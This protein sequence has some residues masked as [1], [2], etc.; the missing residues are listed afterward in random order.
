MASPPP[1]S[2]TPRRWRPAGQPSAVVETL[3]QLS[4]S[5]DP[6]SP[7]QEFL[8]PLGTPAVVDGAAELAANV[9]GDS[10]NR[11][12]DSLYAG[13]EA[14]GASFN[15]APA[16]Q[17]TAPAAAAAALAPSPPSPNPPD[18]AAH[19]ES[20]KPAPAPPTEATASA[21][22]LPAAITAPSTP[23]PPSPVKAARPTK[24]WTPK[25]A[26]ATPTKT[27][28]RASELIRM[29]ESKNDSPAPERRPAGAVA[30]PF[31]EAVA[32]KVPAAS[33]SRQA[34]TSSTPTTT[35]TRSPI[36]SVQKMVAS[37]RTRN[38][39]VTGQ[40]SSL[41]SSTPSSMLRKRSWNVSIRRRR[42][43]EPEDKVAEQVPDDAPE[44]R[45]NSTPPHP[46]PV[47]E[48]SF[49]SQSSLPSP[50]PFPLAPKTLTGEPL[51]TG[52]LFYFNVYED[53]EPEDY[54]WVATDARLYADGLELVWRTPAG[55]K[56]T[57][58]LDVEYCEEVTSTYSPTNPIAN[59][60]GALAARKRG[61][62]FVRGLYP[63]KMVYEDGTE[64]LGC[65]SAIE[66]VRWVKAIALRTLNYLESQGKVQQLHNARI[67]NQLDR[68][69]N[70]VDRSARHF[71]SLDKLELLDE[72]RK[73]EGLVDCLR[74]LS[75]PDRLDDQPPPL[76]SKDSVFAE[77]PPPSPT[78]SVSTLSDTERPVTPP[79]FLLPESF[80][81]RMEDMGHLLGLVMGQQKDI[82]EE[83]AYRRELDA[84]GPARMEAMFAQILHQLE[85]NA[86]HQKPLAPLPRK[87]PAS[88]ESWSEVEG[89]FYP[90]S[91]S[92]YS[93]DFGQRTPA[94]PNTLHSATSL[95]S[96]IPESLLEDDT[97]EPEFDEEYEVGN[98][99]PASPAHEQKQYRT[100][101]P[102][103]VVR[104]R[105]Q[106]LEY[107]SEVEDEEAAEDVERVLADPAPAPATPPQRPIPY[108]Q[109]QAD[110]RPEEETVYRD[111]QPERRRPTTR[112]PPPEPVELPTPVNSE[113]RKLRDAALD[114]PGP[115]GPQSRF[116]RP[117]RGSMHRFGRP[118]SPLSTTYVSRGFR[119]VPL[120][121]FPPP[122][123]MPIPMMAPPLRQGMPAFGRPGFFPPPGYGP[124][125]GGPGM[126]HHHLPP[127]SGGIG[128]TTTA[129]STNSPLPPHSARLSTHGSHHHTPTPSATTSSASVAD[130]AIV[131]PPVHSP[132]PPITIK[133]TPASIEETRSASDGVPSVAPGSPSAATEPVPPPTASAY[134]AF[135]HPM[136]T[137]ST[138]RMLNNTQALGE[139]MGEQQN[140]MA[141]YMHGIS[142]QVHDV[143]AGLSRDLGGILAKLDTLRKDIRP[144]RVHG[145]V[146][147][148]GTVQLSTGEIVDG[149]QGAPPP[150]P[151]AVV[152]P[153]PDSP[154]ILVGRV[155]PDGTVMAG[156]R[157]VVGIQGVPRDPTP[158]ELAEEA[159]RARDL[160]QDRAIDDLAAMGELVACEATDTSFGH[161][162]PLYRPEPPRKSPQ[163]PQSQSSRNAAAGHQHERNQ[164]DQGGYEQ[165]DNDHQGARQGPQPHCA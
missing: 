1:L 52:K 86:Y 121:P 20:P 153:P 34:A 143:N 55:A 57:V 141:R 85:A 163:P 69:E 115:A 78:T 65:E 130:P 39:E 145:H 84:E 13:L 138:H 139:A 74:D 146:L 135:S 25:P 120:G 21:S 156:D 14:F 112:A 19:P 159:Q 50:T 30:T 3:N 155:L 164:G 42:R 108:R 158:E 23:L 122:G 9:T 117:P 76:P 2:P 99:P 40:E 131:T 56:A 67:D 5:P 17:D 94:P 35:R 93:G 154:P 98:L 150:V 152:P 157:I 134:S 27:N 97:L 24:Q 104:Q 100:E 80:N 107:E 106:Q 147:P 162:E 8:S 22:I 72:L 165:H 113:Y 41:S 36:S 136:S 26:A 70:K 160:Q 44:F 58:V 45:P 119:P 92:V 31:R 33:V 95:L 144:E 62:E 49:P 103:A 96:R 109:P 126:Y 10:L 89:D 64:R 28:T 66:R 7:E 60:L 54:Q 37:W 51:R 53:V 102:E 118:R 18:L 124:F 11:R 79:D 148:D 81:Q 114:A 88:S 161:H 71:K 63:F 149:I 15:S 32:V 116:G 87:R 90:G 12:Y 105:N 6:T 16:A 137:T 142:D 46:S 128:T 68:I 140:D 4:D 123:M 83:L 38:A 127:D 59:D 151:V 110:E 77:S 43:N 129:T 47:D 48:A 61:D 125:A 75:K 73:L 82:I 101:V 133:I 132:V 111:E 29:F 91:Q